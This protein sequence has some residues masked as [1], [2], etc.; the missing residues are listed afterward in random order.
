MAGGLWREVSDGAAAVGFLEEQRVAL[1][2]ELKQD[3]KLSL[4]I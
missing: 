1:Q 2:V 4:S 3:A